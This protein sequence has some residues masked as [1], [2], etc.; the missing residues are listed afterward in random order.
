MNSHV[1]RRARYGT[2]GGTTPPAAP[3]SGQ[4]TGSVVPIWASGPRGAGVLGTT[5]HTDLF[6]L[7]Q[8]RNP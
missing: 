1:T 8:G 4:H 2:A 7:L 6:R 3:P 5:D